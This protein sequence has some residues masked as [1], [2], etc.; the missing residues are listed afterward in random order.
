MRNVRDIDVKEKVVILRS[1]FN[2][3]INDGK[4]IDNNRIVSELETI[5]YLINQNSKI[6]IMSH[7]G[8]VKS[9]EDKENLT[10]LP[11][12]E[13]L[14]KLLN[15]EI[16]FSKELRGKDLED[17]ISNLTYGEVL[18]LEN[19][20][21]L[22]YP[23]KLESG[24]DEDL[25]KYWASLADVFIFDAFATSHRAHASTYGISKYLPHAVGFLVEKEVEE[26]NKIKACEKTL[27]LG[28]IKI[29]DKLPLIKKLLHNSEKVLIGGGLS[30]AFLSAKGFNVNKSLVNNSLIDE[31]NDILNSGKVI[32]PVDVVTDNEIKNIEDI[33]ETDNILDIGPK[34]I[35]LYES[36]IDKDKYVL[37]NGTMGKYEDEKYENGTK[38]I[39]DYLKTNNIKTIVC[40]GDGGSASKKF[41]FAPYYLSTGGGA[42]LEYLEDNEMLPLKI[43]EE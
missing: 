41:K 17:M 42:S 26:L 23:D 21:S 27:I 31:V 10:L 2:V 12:K 28:G 38:E 24:C 8:K 9:L 7:L 25:S 18:L 39:L 5:N 43:M 16:K 30:Y 32:I 33:K 4:I 22:D 40:G 36:N 14:E 13:E 3:P 15:R 6:I 11:V 29:D 1:D 20:R 37:M 35:K 34:T 19:T